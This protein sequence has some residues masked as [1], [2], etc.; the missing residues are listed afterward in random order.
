M[1]KIIFTL[2]CSIITFQTFAQSSVSDVSKIISETNWNTKQITENIVFKQ[3]LI[4]IFESK[5]S[6]N[7]LE[8]T[9]SANV[10]LGINDV[11]DTLI[12]TS[13]LCKQVD[14]VA[15]VNASFFDMKNG[16][17][18]DFVRVNEKILH[19][20]TKISQRN[21]AALVI[22]KY[23]VEILERDT[24]DN[25]WENNLNYENV[26]VAGP[27]IMKN[28]M[29]AKLQKN[30]FNENRHPRTFVATKTNGNV[31][32]VVVD[33]RNT[34]A[35][36]MSINELYILAKALNCK[37]A[38]NFDGGGSS[39]MYISGENEN[40]IVN[41]PSDNRLFDHNGERR[42][43]N[44]IYVKEFNP[45]K[46]AFFTD[47][48]TG[49][50]TSEEDLMRCI[51]DVN[52]Q[53]DIDFVII[54]GDVTENGLNSEI[55]TVKNRL[56]KLN[57]KYYAI[58]GNHETKWTESGHTRFAQ[59]F[60]DNKVT[61][62]HNGIKFVGFSSGPVLRMGDAHVSPIEINWLKNTLQSMENIKQPVIVFTHVP[63]I[64][65]AD[66]I[67]NG[68][69]IA[70]IIRKYNT[71]VIL[72]GH[73]HHNRALDADEIP[74]IICRSTLRDKKP[75][76]GYS[77][78]T[79]DADSLKVF[80]RNPIEKTEKHWHSLSMTKEYYS[81]QAEKHDLGN[82]SINSLY[83]DVKIKWQ[84][85][86]GGI[87]TNS[88]AV[89]GNKVIAGNELGEVYCVNS[90]NG[91]IIWKYKTRNSVYST[92]AI[93]KN[94][95]VF[96]SCDSSIY[97]LNIENGT[98]LWEI[99][100]N[101]TVMGTPIIENEIVYIG[102]SDGYF[103]AININNGKIIWKFDGIK[104]YIESKP[105]IYDNK[106]IFGA[107]DTN[108]Y[109]LNKKDGT[110]AWKWNNGH[111]RLHFSPA[112]CIP[113]ANDGKIFIVAPDRFMTAIDASTGKTVWRT[114]KH[115][116]RETI[117]ISEDKSRVYA[118]CF[119][120]TVFC[121]SSTAKDFEELWFAKTG[122]SYDINPSMPVEKDGAVFFVT[123]NGMF[124]A[125]KA[126]NG[127]ILWKHKFRNTIIATLTPLNGS[128][129]IFTTHDGIIGKLTADKY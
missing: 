71:R 101:H 34:N 29:S 117:G 70:D 51:E 50:A 14:A 126:D 8:I 127:K 88:A 87:I 35:A 17:A 91:E 129:V 16:G 4:N 125:L 37:D 86:T 33:G 74:A 28:G 93:E 79:V 41:Y 128:E 114:N 31:L 15:G 43:A 65:P 39:A 106:I 12:V 109:A 6:I 26:I 46:F 67:D 53:S 98:K 120:D 110:L 77:I 5:Q 19:D 7:I 40:G 84:T 104:G 94:S 38:M 92:P 24:T 107:W 18:V 55:E 96:G 57:K 10:R 118:R 32:L 58:A 20:K 108:L 103:R 73:Y 54:N 52:S 9:P 25:N 44:V 89:A 1:K 60:G 95:V 119:V 85:E 36:G 121:I 102:G 112:A 122:Y 3:A 49:T 124:V 69:E 21:N 76:G 116:V 82:D 30:A 115:K 59:V 78:F 27:L 47:I 66:Q 90:E 64:E 99:K 75:V 97:C 48:H 62:K 111:P 61:F 123:K 81:T 80:E 100:T 83:P 23:K 45:F 13:E 113:V 56:D 72:N 2:I 68:H 22:D 11:S 63:L 105:L 42:V